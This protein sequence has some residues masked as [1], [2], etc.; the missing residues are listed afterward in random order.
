MELFL[1]AFD[2]IRLRTW[3]LG[4]AMI[5]GGLVLPFVVARLIATPDNLKPS[6]ILGCYTSAGAPALEVQRSKIV[7]HQPGGPNLSYR[8]DTWKPGGWA[9]DVS[10][11]WMPIKQVS[12]HYEF[13]QQIGSGYYWPLV[14]QGRYGL[15]FLHKSQD[16][17]GLFSMYADDRQL[18]YAKQKTGFYCG[19]T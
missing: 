14:Q 8:L 5:L 15:R 19:S 4:W 3:L 2:H 18:I 1:D 10:P 7:V 9:L 17:A 16:F 13:R 6:V 11:A 12:G